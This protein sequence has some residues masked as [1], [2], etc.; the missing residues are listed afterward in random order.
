MNFLREHLVGY[1][2]MLFHQILVKADLDGPTVQYILIKPNTS[3]PFIWGEVV[4]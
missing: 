2:S 3:S 1:L 4:D